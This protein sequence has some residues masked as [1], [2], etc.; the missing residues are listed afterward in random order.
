MKKD[1]LKHRLDKLKKE[2]IKKMQEQGIYKGPADGVVSVNKRTRD[3]EKEKIQTEIK[4]SSKN[5]KE[6]LKLNAEKDEDLNLKSLFEVEEEKKPE[7]SPS[8]EGDIDMKTIDN[9]LK[10]LDGEVPTTLEPIAPPPPTIPGSLPEVAVEMEKV[11]EQEISPVVEANIKSIAKRI[12]HAKRINEETVEDIEKAAEEATVPEVAKSL[13]KLLK[14]AKSL[15]TKKQEEPTKEPE[16]E[17]IVEKDVDEVELSSNAKSRLKNVLE[18]LQTIKVQLIKEETEEELKQLFSLKTEGEEE[19]A[20]EEKEEKKDESTEEELK[21]LFNFKE[22]V[23][24]VDADEG[25]KEDDEIITS[26]NNIFSEVES[27]EDDIKPEDL[28]N[29]KAKLNSIFKEIDGSGLED[30]ELESLFNDPGEV[31]PIANQDDIDLGLSSL[32]EMEPEEKKPME[33]EESKELKALF[34][35]VPSE[36]DEP[37]ETEIKSDDVVI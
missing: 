29:I 19:S 11:A 16:N 28:Q 23:A 37:E 12:K 6:Y 22:E 36:D 2:A 5:L 27:G 24:T 35:E 14:R 21:S 15:Q 26:I 32:F 17:P 1:E 34:E 31:R 33:T 18:G 4:I 9:L 3:P 13:K 20:E 7:G 10:E 8:V 25:K 30:G